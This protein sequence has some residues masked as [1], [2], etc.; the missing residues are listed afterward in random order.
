MIVSGKLFGY[1]LEC[2][3]RVGY[4]GL[5]A[6]MLQNGKFYAGIEGF[7]PVAWNDLRGWGQ[8]SER[9]HLQAGQTYVLMAE[10]GDIVHMRLCTEYGAVIYEC[11]GTRAHYYSPYTIAHGRFEVVSNGQIRYLSLKPLNAYHGCR[12][13]VLDAM[14][15]LHPGTLRVP[16]G[17]FAE[18]YVWKDGFLP[19]PERPVI[20]DGGLSLLFSA[21]NGYDGYELNIDDYAAI[22]RYV[23][24]EMEY[25]VR[26]SDNDPQDAANL[27]EYCNGSADTQYG[28]LRTARGFAEPYRVKTWYIG[29]EIAWLKD[30]NLSNVDSAIR[31]ND[32]FVRA[33]KRVDASIHTVVS[34]GNEP[35]WD[36]LFLRSASEVEWCGHHYYLHDTHPDADPALLAR[37]ACEITLPRLENARKLL[38]S[39]PM[40]FDEWNTRWG[41]FGSG[42]SALY[43]AGVLCM[44][45]KNADRLNLR[46][47]SYFALVN[48]GAIRVYPD[49]VTLAPDGEILKRMALHI[50]GKLLPTEDSDT[51]TTLHK[52]Y[53]YTT[54]CNPSSKQAK[55]IYEQGSCEVLTLIEGELFIQQFE[56]GLKTIPPLSVAFIRRETMGNMEL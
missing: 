6:E 20:T 30:S 33:M 38:G 4:G 18:R 48:E 3:R 17:C 14:K 37:A 22:S 2:T 1:N 47:A 46:G 32:E 40:V 9:I 10:A 50:G 34:T 27:V 29:N 36:E 11:K 41:S 21:N 35:C 24:A 56:K 39:F 42:S 44:L 7:Y 49:H 8:C 13:D 23:N 28:A 51:V 26:L 53:R 43:A 55:L 15:E 25:T 12:K 5:Y 45:I 54:V 52:G 16:G 31:K 19:I